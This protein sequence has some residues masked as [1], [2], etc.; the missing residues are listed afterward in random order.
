[1]LFICILFA[2]YLHI[3]NKSLNFAT[4]IKKIMFINAALDSKISLK[5]MSK[6]LW[7][8]YILLLT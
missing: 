8:I 6:R 5:G 7:H 1:M 4:E 3:P 2:I